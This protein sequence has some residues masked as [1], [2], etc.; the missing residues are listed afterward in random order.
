[1]KDHSRWVLW[2]ILPALL[3]LPGCRVKAPVDLD[4]QGEEL[5]HE[6]G[7]KSSV[8]LTPAAILAAD[9]KVTPAV[10]RVLSRRLTAPGELELN[11]RRLAHLTAR[12]PGRVER[13]FAVEGD[14]VREGQ[15]LAEVYSPDYMGIQ[16]E[17]LQAAERVKRHA[18]NPAE[19]GPARAFLAS[20]R[21]RLL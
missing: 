1:M 5:E 9:I 11:S 18:E 4:H 7:V 13:L 12:T 3:L 17:Y 8:T 16:A 14:R 2:I 21:E 15:V 20:A 19:A 10:T 6:A